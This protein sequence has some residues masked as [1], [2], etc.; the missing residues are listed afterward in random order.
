MKYNFVKHEILNEINKALSSINLKQH[1]SL[2][3]NLCKG[4]RIFLIAIGRVFL[5][6]QCLGKRLS[7]LGLDVEIVGSIT[8]KPITKKDLLIVASGSGESILPLAITK[9]AK[10]IGCRIFHITSASKSSIR[11]LADFVLEIKT[12]TKVIDKN[13][14]NKNLFDMSSKEGK[15]IQPMSSLFDQVLHI[16][17]DIISIEIIEKLKIDKFKILKNHAN[18]E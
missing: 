10:Q 12:P 16:Y 9:K 11:S 13:I 7:H 17:G 14:I 1:Q 5:S 2:I 3:D 18:L 8:E 4:N 15:S 6:L